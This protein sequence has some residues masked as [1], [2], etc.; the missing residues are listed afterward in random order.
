VDDRDLD[1]HGSSR[2]SRISSMAPSESDHAADS[3][4]DSFPVRYPT[5]LHRI[6]LYPLKE[7]FSLLEVMG[8]AFLADN[9]VRN[10]NFLQLILSF[11]ILFGVTIFLRVI[12]NVR[13]HELLDGLRDHHKL[14]AGAL[15]RQARRSS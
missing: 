3:M 8:I 5:F 14:V 2:G 9:F 6:L 13:D 10:H 15:R 1:K 12:F 7:R 4:R 11:L